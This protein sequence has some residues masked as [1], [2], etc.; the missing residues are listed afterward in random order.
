M[1]PLTAFILAL[2]PYVDDVE[3]FISANKAVLGGLQP[4]EKA[5]IWQAM[6]A[7]HLLTAS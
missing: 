2:L 4:E 1:T 7:R 6:K 5:R 3:G